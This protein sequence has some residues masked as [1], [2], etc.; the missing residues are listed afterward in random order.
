VP[1]HKCHSARNTALAY[2]VRGECILRY[3]NEVGTALLY[4]GVLSKTDDGRI[5]FPYE[6][7][8]VEFQGT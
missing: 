4:A 3:D 7:V 6:A 5:V 1:T 2:V 8:K